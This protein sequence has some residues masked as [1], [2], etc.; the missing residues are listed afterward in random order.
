MSIVLLNFEGSFLI[1]TTL[2]VIKR[3]QLALVRIKGLSESERIETDRSDKPIYRPVAN[4]AGAGSW[5]L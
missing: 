3:L 1:L 2:P 5:S 4:L